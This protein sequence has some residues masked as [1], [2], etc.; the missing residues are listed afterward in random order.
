MGDYPQ[1]AAQNFVKASPQIQVSFSKED[2]S[3]RESRNVQDV[4]PELPHV[5]DTN[6]KENSEASPHSHD[7]PPELEV[8][9]SSLP[10]TTQT[11]Q[12][13]SEK[14]TSPSTTSSSSDSSDQQ[15]KQSP[16]TNKPTSS[17]TE[18]NAASGRKEPHQPSEG[19]SDNSVTSS[20][21]TSSAIAPKLVGVDLE[22]VIEEES[23]AV[24]EELEHQ[25]QIIYTQVME[26]LAREMEEWKAEEKK[27]MNSE[28]KRKIR[29][30]T[31]D[32]AT[33]K[34]VLEDLIQ[35]QAYQLRDIELNLEN[36]KAS[37][38]Q[39]VSEQ[40]QEREL[41]LRVQMLQQLQQLHEKRMSALNDIAAVAHQQSSVLDRCLK[42][43]QNNLTAQQELAR[44]AYK[45]D[46]QLTQDRYPF[47]ET[48]DALVSV[49]NDPL[50]ATSIEKTKDNL[51]Q[52]AKECGVSSLQ[53]L[54][55]RFKSVSK[56]A[57]KESFVSE[58]SPG[59]LAQVYAEI[60]GVVTVPPARATKEC[61]DSFIANASTALEN[62]DLAQAYAE[63]QKVEGRAAC[64]LKD[65]MQAA[66][67]RLL[68]DQVLCLVKASSAT[69]QPPASTTFGLQ[70]RRV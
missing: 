51:S 59:L 33:E 23:R 21:D 31:R 53:A 37:I 9:S 48:L 32:F 8:T 35:Q 29:E 28:V 11:T 65:W 16:T 44:L 15:Q 26:T 42:R 54:T 41:N 39:S 52:E 13:K 36:F 58:E 6:N 34:L 61:A 66:S 40:F 27:K 55:S 45:L 64:A 70:E 2:S 5:T 43:M 14:P 38:V 57:R 49:S 56:V 1:S 25:Y 10:S 50:I 63:L 19:E 62:G 20:K 17:G 18:T 68:M 46:A 60:M 3:S 4:S 30:E 67:D 22:D 24:R 47:L 69:P 7:Y 12:E